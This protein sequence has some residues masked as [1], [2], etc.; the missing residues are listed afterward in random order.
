MRRILGFFYAIKRVI[1][2]GNRKNK[3]MS[4][5]YKAIYGTRPKKFIKPKK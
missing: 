2:E 4:E 3:A 5:F 1:Q